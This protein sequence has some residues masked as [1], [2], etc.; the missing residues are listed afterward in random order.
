MADSAI[1]HICHKTQRVLNLL[2]ML[3]RSPR[4]ASSGWRDGDDPKKKKDSDMCRQELYV[5]TPKAY[6]VLFIKTCYSGWQVFRRRC[7]LS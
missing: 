5:L 4:A 1:A 2:N 7:T 3:V 6:M